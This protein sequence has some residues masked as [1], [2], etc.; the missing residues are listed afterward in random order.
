GGQKDLKKGVSSMVDQLSDLTDGLNDS[1]DGLK[2]VSS[3]IGDARDFI[4]ELS[5]SN[6]E[7]EGFYIPDEALDNDDFKQ[8]LDQY[9]SDNRKMTTMDVTLSDNPYSIEAI[10]H[11]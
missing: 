9:M 7:L 1:V 6:S 4:E 8:G 10:D 11:I 2:D 3:G 5:H